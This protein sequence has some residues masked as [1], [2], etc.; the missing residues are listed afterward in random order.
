MLMVTKGDLAVLASY[1]PQSL[2]DLCTTA[3]DSKT[4]AGTCR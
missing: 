2:H 4:I 1:L 3:V